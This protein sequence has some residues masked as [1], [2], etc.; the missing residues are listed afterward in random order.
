MPR[1]FPRSLNSARSIRSGRSIVKESVLNDFSAP[2]AIA[3]TLPPASRRTAATPTASKLT[4]RPRTVMVFLIGS[5]MTSF[6]PEARMIVPS[7]RRHWPLGFG[8]IIVVCDLRCREQVVCGEAPSDL[9]RAMTA[10]AQPA[11][12]KAFIAIGRAPLPSKAF[13][14]KSMVQSPTRYR[15]VLPCRAAL[16][17]RSATAC[18][19]YC[20]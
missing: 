12:S 20:G 18:R 3:S 5:P 8:T 13:P 1:H 7:I 14:S 2:A 16:T 11:P 15:A 17:K 6:S 4:S 9:S 10:W 19:S